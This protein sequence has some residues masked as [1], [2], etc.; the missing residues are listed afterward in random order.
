MS[1]KIKIQKI[2]SEGE[3]IEQFWVPTLNVVA[4]DFAS[5]AWYF[6]GLDVFLDKD[7]SYQAYPAVANC[8]IDGLNALNCNR[9]GSDTTGLRGTFVRLCL[10]IKDPKGALDPAGLEW[11]TTCSL[12][13]PHL[14]PSLFK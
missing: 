7:F 3:L 5:H 11:T 12:P 9:F 14:P 2:L 8:L 13:R 6:T 10:K 1:T 4:A